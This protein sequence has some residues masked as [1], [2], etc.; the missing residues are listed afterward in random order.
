[1]V[2]SAGVVQE[3]AQNYA[4][5]IVKFDILG[6]TANFARKISLPIACTNVRYSYENLINTG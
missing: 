2:C 3:H 4:I 5:N 6:P 1:M